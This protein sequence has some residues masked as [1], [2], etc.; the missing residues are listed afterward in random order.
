[1]RNI[2]SLFAHDVRRLFANVMS[3]I[4]TVG[5]VVIPSIFAWYNIIACWDVFDNTGNLTV[6]VANSDAGYESD[7]V[8][9][10]VNVGD[11]VVSALRANDQIN[12]TFTDEADAID[13]VEAGRYYA[14]VVIPASFSRDMLSFYSDDMQ[15]ADIVYYSNEKKNAVAPRIIGQGADTVSYQINEVFA[16]TVSEVALSLASSLN[17]FADSENIDASAAAL[18]E[19]L[20]DV[21]DG[22]DQAAAVLDLYGSLFSSAGELANSSAALIQAARGEVANLQP[23]LDAGATGIG[24][25]AGELQQAASEITTALDAVKSSM[26]SVSDAANGMLDDAGVA[27]SA[28]SEQM[29]TQAEAIAGQVGAFNDLA[30]QLDALAASD[31]LPA[32][33][34]PAAQAAAERM[35][36]TAH[37]LDDLRGK[38]NT[39]ADNL[40]A[41]VAQSQQQRDEIASLAEQAKQSADDIKTSFEQDLLPSITDLAGQAG[42]LA[43]NVASGLNALDGVA[44]TVAGSTGSAT[45]LLASAEATAAD[46]AGKLRT[47]GDEL[48]QLA[49]DVTAALASGD[50]DELKRLIGGDV[51][52]FA[53]ALAAPVGIERVAVYPV[54][55]FGSAMAPLYATLAL[56]IG[57]LL[58]MVAVRPVP[59]QRALDDLPRPPRSVELYLGRFGVVAAL[60]LAQ[61]TL[62]A[63]GN[64]FFLGVQVAEP[65]LYLLCF[66][67][68]G[69]VFVFIIYTLVSTF[70][71]LGKAIAVLLLIVQVTGCGGSYPLSL[72]PGFVQALSPWLPATHALEA[73]RA[74]MMGVY[75]GDFWIHLGILAAFVIPAAVLGIVLRKPISR[76]MAWYIKKVE[77]SKL[78][79]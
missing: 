33:A 39:A 38:L 8:P 28:S 15:H 56:F 16:E 34:R 32:D 26:D 17:N 51:Q 13:G 2:M 68:A 44:E 49:D 78:V 45:D 76:L 21:A 62:M 67:V 7:L 54:E 37:L 14:A 1:M 61:S 79:G 59:S 25:T 36:Q 72:L 5:L 55:N 53:H 27:A 65:L 6:A 50:S 75:Q 22:A 47:S 70:A 30:N 52:A 35:R 31:D 74:A 71:N 60:S 73:M 9:L 57:S 11:Q 77:A 42:A 43:D 48:R 41:G 3:V 63:L 20:R 4:I 23:T 40:D 46:A 24:Q 18:A 64:M 12:W 10:R 29:R 66:W 58:I 69:L 19:R